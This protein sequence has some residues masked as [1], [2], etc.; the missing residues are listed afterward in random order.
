MATARSSQAHQKR[1]QKI[2][3]DAADQIAADAPFDEEVVVVVEELPPGESTRTQRGRTARTR[4]DVVDTFTGM[5]AQSQQLVADGI[6]RWIDL[7]RG[8]SSTPVGA[9]ATFGGLFDARRL[10]E[11]SF[12]FAAELLSSQKEFTLKVLEAMTPAKAA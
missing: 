12:R 3:E 7:A 6:N 5:L 10:T 11:E 1:V 2:A 9:T 4:P 8:I